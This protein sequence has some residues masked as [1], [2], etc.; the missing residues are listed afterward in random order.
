VT[1]PTAFAVGPVCLSWSVAVTLTVILWP[2]SAAI[3]RYELC[4]WRLMFAQRPAG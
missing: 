3:S 1:G 4:V 2:T